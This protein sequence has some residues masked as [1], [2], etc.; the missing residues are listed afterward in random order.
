MNKNKKSIL[1]YPAGIPQKEAFIEAKRQGLRIVSVDRNP[2]APLKQLADDFYHLDPSDETA[3]LKFLREYKQKRVL[4][5]VLIVGCD[6]PVSCAVAGEELGTPA[7]GKSSAILTVDKIAMKEQFKQFDVSTP[8]F[9]AVSSGDEVRQ[10]VENYNTRMIIK[11]NDNC[12]ARGVMQLKPGDDYNKIFNYAKANS[13][14]DGKVILEIFEEGTQISIEGLVYEKVIV[15][16]FADRNYEYIDR[17]FPHVIENG[18]TMPTALSAEEKGALIKEFIKGVKA[19]GIDNSVAKGDIVY[20]EN[21]PKVIEIAGRVSGG[22]FASM[23]VPESTGVNLLEAAISL[24]TGKAPEIEKL[25]PHFERG[26]AVRYMFPPEG[27]LISIEGVEEARKIP[28]VL[29]LVTLVK[30]GEKVGVIRSHAD[31]A[32]W[33]VAVGNNRKE[34]VQIVEKAI[35]SVVFNVK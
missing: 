3:F 9:F 31:R 4:D 11:P 14:K 29:E 21:G 6:L 27:I 13:K 22:K 18:A 34:A 35:N 16:G 30:P 1:L 25:K 20:G 24:A 10:I 7:I 28:G 32:G 15:T 8:D 2:D 12:G 33:V 26:V 5:G 23:L 17:F 19:L